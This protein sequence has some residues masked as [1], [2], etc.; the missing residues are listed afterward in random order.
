M[1]SDLPFI[2]IFWL[3][4]LFIGIVNFPLTAVLF[5]NFIDRGYL[6]AKVLGLVLI[7]YIVWL[8]ASL[9]ILPFTFTS[10]IAV[11]LLT[12]V[13][14]LLIFLKNK[15]KGIYKFTAK[16]IQL[17][18]L[19]EIL[20]MIGLTFWSTIRGYAPEIHGLEKFMDFG[21]INSILHSRF[22][23]PLD[24]W[25]TASP[26]YPYHTVNYYY[27]GHFVTALLTKFSIVA[28][29]IAYNIML[30]VL[31]AF[32]FTGS[33]SIA[34]NLF[35]VFQKE[36]GLVKNNLFN[37]KT[38]V[39]GL[40]AGFLVA[41]G[42]NLH[43]IYAF[44]RGYS[45]DKPQPF[46]Q[47]L[48][49]PNLSS[50]W[51]PNATRFIPN[52]IHEFPIYSFVVSDLHGHVLD[53]PF[54]LLTIAFLFSILISTKKSVSQNLNNQNSKLFRIFNLRFIWNFILLGLLLAVMY[55]TNA[56][57]GIIYL[58]L[59][60]LVLLTINT[61][62]HPKK[63]YQPENQRLKINRP[64]GGQ[65]YNLK[66]K[67]ANREISIGFLNLIIIFSTLLFTYF[68]FAL[69][70]NRNFI[71]F[72]KGIGLNCFTPNSN[73]Q[74]LCDHSPIWMLA[75]LWG[76]FS[77]FAVSFLIWI[78]LPAIRRLFNPPSI[79]HHLSSSIT[80]SDIFVT[81]LII[82][83]AGLL[84]APE[85]IFARDIYPVHYR[86]NTMFKLGYQAFM[87]LGIT[88]SYIFFRFRAVS[89]FK[90][91][92]NNA[93]FKQMVI[94]KVGKSFWWI[95]AFLQLFLVAIYPYF[96]TNSYYASLKN[97]QSLD[98]L[99]WLNRSYP[100]DWA[101]VQYF[102]RNLP[103]FAQPTILEAVGE[104]Y[105]DYARISANTGLPTVVGWPVHEW[106]WRGSYDEAGKRLEEVRRIYET[107]NIDEAKEL[108][109]KYK[110]EYVV[111]GNMEREKYPNLNEI[112][113]MNLGKVVFQKGYTRVYKLSL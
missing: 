94:H 17:F 70:F 28:P 18:F 40:L 21:F 89:P 48:G 83:S 2:Y 103:T 47:V 108:L 67:I 98:G 25:L 73:G 39:C 23:P 95:L 13:V 3:I 38:I 99:A 36:K 60:G 111:I 81:L 77:Y 44:T 68:V 50:Y 1:L 6:F 5:K 64:T 43:T 107:T 59:S 109:T 97:Y 110:V 105:T 15:S 61:Q 14:N 84:I 4:F 90:K 11:S 86:A 112:T 75:I 113:F 92:E 58:G 16:Q 102:R 45:L 31:F 66:F 12:L 34:A 88:V 71:P 63:L 51:Y 9:K 42:G 7:S 24:M 56:W 85:F 10:I 30:G 8:G 69:P 41:L 49:T 55:M 72:A 65:K 54:V 46:W 104:S 26:N 27:F 37:S 93:S 101:V 96:A 33:F 79:I 20:F 82:I 76:Y 100:E 19:E 35:A 53:I 78:I 52:T 80:Q 62:L 22:M 91:P 74:V 57:D 32:T 87:M 106:L 29:E